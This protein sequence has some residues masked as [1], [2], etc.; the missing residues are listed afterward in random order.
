MEFLK[1][2]LVALL[3]SI[4]LLVITRITG[5]RQVSELTFFDYING[6]SIGSIAAAGAVAP[7]RDFYRYLIAM[8]IFGAVSFFLAKITDHSVSVRHLVSGKPEILFQKGTFHR[9]TMSRLHLDLS[10]LLMLCR[11][12]GYF[13]LAQIDTVLMEVNGKIS[14]L[15]V[16]AQKPAT[17]TELNTKVKQE[18][19]PVCVILDAELQ[20]ETLSKLGFTLDWL[21]KKLKEYKQELHSVFLGMLSPSGTLSVYSVDEDADG[22]SVE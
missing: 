18:E 16:T 21:Q 6:I 9:K 20:T 17:P 2:T 12:A 3:S 5:R 22:Q 19:L 11:N 14:I 13:D 10:E 1:I 15:P 8:V 7:I 4:T